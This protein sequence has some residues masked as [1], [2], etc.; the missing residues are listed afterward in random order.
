VVNIQNIGFFNRDSVNIVVI[1][2][3]YSNN[4]RGYQQWGQQVKILFPFIRKC[5][6]LC[7]HFEQNPGVEMQC[8][9]QT[10][11]LLT[12]VKIQAKFSALT[13]KHVDE[14]LIRYGK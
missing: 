1:L 3:G 11:R 2:S 8:I 9:F 13:L 6:E 14:L 12:D 5:H 7:A 4:F 10:N